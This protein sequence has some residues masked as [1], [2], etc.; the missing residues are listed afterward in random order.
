M[1]MKIKNKILAYLATLLCIGTIVTP[2]Q[3]SAYKANGKYY[4]GNYIPGDNVNTSLTLRSGSSFDSSTLGIIYK[5]DYP[6]TDSDSIRITKIT[7]NLAG[8]TNSVR[9]RKNGRIEELSGYVNLNYCK[10]NYMTHGFYTIPDGTNNVDRWNEEYVTLW[11][12]GVRIYASNYNGNLN[13]NYKLS[14]EEYIE[15]FGN[16]SVYGPASKG[17]YDGNVNLSYLLPSVSSGLNQNDT[18]KI[19]R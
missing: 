1:N 10:E 6:G 13:G 5:T 7:S 16:G 9:T 4:L 15:V 12:A 8:W 19:I 17:G 14:I 3:V 18:N 2:L 11:G